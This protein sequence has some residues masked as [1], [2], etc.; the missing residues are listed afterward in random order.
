MNSRTSSAWT[1]QR[2]IAGP[3]RVPDPTDAGHS[4]APRTDAVNA[5]EEN[6]D[7]GIPEGPG[8]TSNE[9]TSN[10]RKIQRGS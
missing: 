8:T 6:R 3:G 9:V 5:S 4:P 1:P 10:N 7:L 2:R